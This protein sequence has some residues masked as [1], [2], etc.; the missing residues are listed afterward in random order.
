[1]LY[2]RFVL[3]HVIRLCIE[4]LLAGEILFHL[5]L[6][7]VRGSEFLLGE[8][9]G[10]PCGDLALNFGMLVC[11]SFVH[12]AAGGAGCHDSPSSTAGG[13]S[14]TGTIGCGKC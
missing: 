1:M 13:W 4:L 5:L 14:V 8:E 2:C 3:L 6:M 9:R 11:I 10:N 7:V 12:T